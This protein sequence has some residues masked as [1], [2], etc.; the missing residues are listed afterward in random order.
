MAIFANKRDSE[1]VPILV[2]IAQ[3]DIDNPEEVD[4]IVRFVVGDDPSIG[5]VFEDSYKACEVVQRTLEGLAVHSSIPADCL[6][7]LNGFNPLAHRRWELTQESTKDSEDP[8]LVL[9]GDELITLTDLEFE[10]RNELADNII[11]EEELAQLLHPIV[12]EA[13]QVARSGGNVSSVV[14]LCPEC[15]NPMLHPTE[16]HV[17]CSRRCAD[18]AGQRKRR[19][20]KLLSHK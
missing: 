10:S 11:F 2:Q 8:Y 17:Y 18:R 12:M 4:Y 20:E 14:G 15:D 5:I 19:K 3:I 6:E 9:R 7:W 16:N 13:W 1:L